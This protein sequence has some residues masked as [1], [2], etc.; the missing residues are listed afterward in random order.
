MVIGAFAVVT[1]VGRRGDDRHDLEDFR[2]LARREPALAALL[3]LFL[4]AQA[5]VPLTAGFVAK[6]SVFEAAID[7]GQYVLALVGM[8][9]TAIAAYVYLR[10]VLAVYDTDGDT[11]PA[12]ARARLDLAT[13]TALFVTAAI[14]LVLGVVP[15][16]VL[17]FARDATLLVAGAR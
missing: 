3:T 7:V 16:T 14:V 9:A 13:G 6:L 4:L 2:G 1:V 17:D 15:G 12:P 10:I 11:A 5:G 8:L